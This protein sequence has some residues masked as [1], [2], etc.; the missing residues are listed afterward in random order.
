VL[1]P[2]REIEVRTDGGVVTEV[3]YQGDVPNLIDERLYRP[4]ARWSLAAAA[5][6]RRLQ[7]GSLGM[8]VGYLIGLVLVVLVVGR[9][10][11]L[12]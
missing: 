12:G 7:S 10:G 6:A 11:W 2:R 4:V 5:Y 3:G 8:Y 1:R 9:I